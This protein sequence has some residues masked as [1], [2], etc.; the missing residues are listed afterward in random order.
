VEK[1]TVKP[2]IKNACDI[3]VLT[4]NR[5]PRHG[6]QVHVGLDVDVMVDAINALERIRDLPVE[7]PEELLLIVSTC[8]D[9]V[10]SPER[11]GN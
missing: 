4:S 6:E 10:R 5:L 8:I 1:T 7:V 9:R 2:P 11:R 3:A